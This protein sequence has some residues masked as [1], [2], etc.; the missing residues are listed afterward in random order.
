MKRTFALIFLLVFL[1]SCSTALLNQNTDETIQK[2]FESD[3]KVISLDELV[4][5][6]WDSAWLVNGFGEEVSL[7][8]ELASLEPLN[9]P[10]LVLIKEKKLEVYDF[11]ASA[12]LLYPKAFYVT[13]FELDHESEFLID[14]LDGKYRLLYQEDGVEHCPV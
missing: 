6:D 9:E 8:E 4:K 5:E 1:V 14:K 12:V 10:R 11:P 2:R 3:V 7:P 13:A